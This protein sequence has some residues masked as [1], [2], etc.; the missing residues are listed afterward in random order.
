MSKC[1]QC[2]AIDDEISER[3][4]K[5]RR[6]GD[7]AAAFAIVGVL[8]WLDG[9]GYN[10]NAIEWAL[11]RL[12]IYD[13]DRK[14]HL[15]SPMRD[16]LYE[17]TRARNEVLHDMLRECKDLLRECQARL[18]RSVGFDV[19]EIAATNGGDRPMLP[20]VDYPDDADER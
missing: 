20:G 14:G 12:A 6:M 16:G 8:A 3:I 5:R 1:T 2:Q 10:Q 18:L 19:H 15:R 13:G 9:L 4:D 11:F 7:L 17:D